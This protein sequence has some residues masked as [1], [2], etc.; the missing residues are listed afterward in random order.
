MVHAMNIGE[1]LP[2]P[3][4]LSIVLPWAAVTRGVVVD[5][6]GQPQPHQIV[7][8]RDRDGQLITYEFT[9]PD[10]TFVLRLPPGSKVDL[11]VGKQQ[12]RR[13]V[14][15]DVVAGIRNVMVVAPK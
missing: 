13:I 6:G 14:L 10:G 11:A 4:E 7:F 8:A 5:E 9:S 12:P 2:G 1:V 15:R 3:G